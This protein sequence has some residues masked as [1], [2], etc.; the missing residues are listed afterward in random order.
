M[1][2]GRTFEQGIFTF[3]LQGNALIELGI[4]TK[5]IRQTSVLGVP[6]SLIDLPR[7][8]AQISQWAAGKMRP[9]FVFV[10]EVASLMLAREEPRLLELH[11]QA[12]LIVPDGMPLVWISRLKGF[13]T[14]VGRVAGADLVKSV[15]E[16]SMATGQSHY[17]YGGKPGVA[18]RMADNLAKAFPGLKI[19]GVR[20]PPMLDIGPDFSFA[21][22]SMADV[23][24]I[25]DSGADFVWVG[26]SSPKQEYWMAK[27]AP[28][29]GSGVFVGVGAA[30]DFHAGTVQRAPAWMQR[31]GLEWLH[32]LCSEPQRLWRRYL[33]LAPRFV[34]GC[35]FELFRESK[36]RSG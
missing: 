35:M 27:A 2:L 7:A 25:R 17:F 10:R 8:T 30:F 24:A 14:E 9:H 32:R 22:S 34:V 23:E 18:Q 29:I 20:S 12:S 1:F 26:V 4:E 13:G 19:A 16:L 31:N 36:V 21:G 28:L 3:D 5:A 6:V 11:K 33:V 15:C